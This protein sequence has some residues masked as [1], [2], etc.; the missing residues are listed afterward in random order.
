MF[1]QRGGG[2]QEAGGAVTALGGAQLGEGD[3]ERVQVW[4]LAKPLDGHDRGRRLDLDR[5]GEA[6]QHWQAV[7]EHGAGAALAE[8]AAVL[9]AGEVEVFAQDLEQGLVHRQ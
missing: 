4:S 7:D 9:R 5:Q 1:E 6:A 3:L 2:D 8:L